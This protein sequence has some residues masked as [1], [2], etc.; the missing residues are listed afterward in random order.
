MKDACL[1][2]TNAAIERSFET[3]VVQL[4]GLV[5]AGEAQYKALKEE[6]QRTKEA[7]WVDR[8]VCVGG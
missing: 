2:E 6:M 4:R 1:Q 3:E 8:Q 5:K 7:H